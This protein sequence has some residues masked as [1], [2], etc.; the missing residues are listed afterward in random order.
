MTQG[1]EASHRARR[2]D[3]PRIL[4]REGVHV[5]HDASQSIGKHTNKIVYSADIPD[6]KVSVL[7]SNEHITVERDGKVTTQ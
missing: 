6:D 7:E 5:S 1:Q 4:Y 3:H 2:Q